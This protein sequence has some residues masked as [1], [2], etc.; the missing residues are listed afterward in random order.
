MTAKVILNPY[1]N[2][3]TAG[4]RQSEVET[5]LTNAGVD[6]EIACT[7]SAG[8]AIELAA[9]AVQDGFNP[10]I[11]AGG[12]GTYGEVING[13]AQA[14]GD[15]PAPSFG[16]MPLGTA[17]DLPDNL[18][19]PK[20]LSEAAQVIAE[21]KT[22]LID[23][24]RVNERYFINNSAMGLEPY[25]TLKHEKI[26]RIKGILRY[27]VAA[28]QG[29]MDKP[30]W[31][32]KMSWDGGEY[33]GPANLVTVGN[34]A[35]TGG[36]FWM[37]PGA[38]PFDGKLTFVHGH[39]PGRLQILTLLP[40]AMDPKGAFIEHPDVHQYDTT[41]LR[42]HCTTPSPYHTDGEIVELEIQDLEY[43]IHPQRLPMLMSIEG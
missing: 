11:A 23:L 24:G 34:C 30:C 22:R 39:R 13:I 15:G 31:D 5:A 38:D 19:I 2:R 7:E 42:I 6:F 1:S 27:L 28:L 8:H 35:R 40:K 43:R 32:V 33:E 12:D 37:S 17:N 26:K 25:I 20:V 3:W 10:I 9:Q 14:A 36:M 29:I 21:R 4:E 41:W 18:G 16:I